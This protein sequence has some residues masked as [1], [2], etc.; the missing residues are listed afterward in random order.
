METARR[1]FEKQLLGSGKSL[2]L[3]AMFGYCCLLFYVFGREG[4]MAFG[5]DL[6]GLNAFHASGFFERI[7]NHYVQLNARLGEATLAS[8]WSLINSVV[9][10]DPFSYPWWFFKVLSL[11]VLFLS[12]VLFLNSIFSKFKP[13]LEL[14]VS[15]AYFFYFSYFG[16]NTLISE[17]LPEVAEYLANYCLPLVIEA[18]LFKRLI[19]SDPS[20]LSPKQL[21]ISLFLFFFVCM[22]H[23]LVWVSSFP[24]FFGAALLEAIK[25]SPLSA[26]KKY[27]P[28]AAV[29]ALVA[30]CFALSPGQRL[31]T[32]S[33][34]DHALHFERWYQQT[35]TNLTALF[36]LPSPLIWKAL[37][38][39]A[40][41]LS[42]FAIFRSLK[43]IKSSDSLLP[44]WAAF[45]FLAG[46][47]GAA[48]TLISGYYPERAR[49]YPMLHFA[50]STA[51]VI[52][53]FFD[54]I[55]MHTRRFSVVILAGILIPLFALRSIE[56]SVTS[57]VNWSK[58]AA[59]DRTRYVT[60]QQIGALAT[61][62]LP[63]Q[64][65]TVY[66]Q[67]CPTG[68]DAPWGLQAFQR[69]G[70]W[71]E[72]LDLK[73][74]S[75][76]T[77]DYFTPA[78]KTLWPQI[79]G[80]HSCPFILPKIIAKPMPG[81]VLKPIA[82]FIA[83]DPKTY[84]SPRGKVQVIF[85]MRS[86]LKDCEAKVSFNSEIMASPSWRD[87]KRFEVVFAR[88]GHVQGA[89]MIP[90]IGSVAETQGAKK[91]KLTLKVVDSTGQPGSY[92]YAK[93]VEDGLFDFF[94]QTKNEPA[95]MSLEVDN[96]SPYYV[97]AYFEAEM[98]CHS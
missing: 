10:R 20:R 1:T 11:F 17:H 72:Q 51:I 46:I 94:V 5:D 78:N 85:P 59:R 41:M 18:Y 26:W 84:S 25:I 77:N 75:V 32:V 96:L 69:W 38:P 4:L 66:Y 42:I 6:N 7:S 71:P 2:T 34:G 44:Y 40:L 60:Y 56:H 19:L 39:L 22:T 16:L 63:S 74:E 21:R 67:N 33:T 43:N 83:V 70:H 79:A 86:D 54:F 53:I 55:L 97:G 61:T 49:F 91:N 80:T 92:V 50:V 37:L 28:I 89:E 64:N 31:R 8:T 9:G 30:F 47:L 13:K 24:L 95:F 15:L 93:T 98:L 58:W 27:R 76:N 36:D 48:S 35:A 68:L 29:Q 87:V 88:R 62:F 45:F 52:S 23:E 73:I 82:T 57:T 65:V 3:F 81:R 14:G 90:E 12:G